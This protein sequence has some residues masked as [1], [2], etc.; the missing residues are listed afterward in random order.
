[1]TANTFTKDP[2]ATLDYGFNWS[3]WLD[4]GE[5]IT[6]Y[7]INTSPC[8]IVNE[9]STSTSGCVI[10][11]LSSGSVGQRYSVSCLIETSGSRIDERT[12]KI[13]VRNR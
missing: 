9:Y 4:T 2:H 13:D 10:V 5:V 11:W 7:T 3:E 8:G 6:G 1:M 12:I